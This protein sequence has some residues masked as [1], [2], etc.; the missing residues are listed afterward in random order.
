MF[1]DSFARTRCEP[2]GLGGRMVLL[3]FF[4]VSRN[5]SSEY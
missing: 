5:L 1:L 2:L 3:I 4:I